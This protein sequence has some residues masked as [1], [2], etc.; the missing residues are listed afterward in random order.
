MIYIMSNNNK[1]L[2]KFRVFLKNSDKIKIKKT[3]RGFKKKFHNSLE[4]I[5]LYFILQEPL[6]LRLFSKKSGK[7]K[8]LIIKIKESFTL[9]GNN[10]K[11]YRDLIKNNSNK[12]EKLLKTEICKG[13]SERFYIIEN[14]LFK[15]IIIYIY[16]VKFLILIVKN[17]IK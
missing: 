4:P 13:F 15:S 16:I 12:K 8:L 5:K 14:E 9:I 10:Q 3:K 7:E 11:I 2:R 6:G 17:L 1:N